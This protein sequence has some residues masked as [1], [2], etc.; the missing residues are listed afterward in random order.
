MAKKRTTKREILEWCIAISYL[1]WPCPVCGRYVI[2]LAEFKVCK[3]GR[4]ND[5]RIVDVVHP[6]CWDAYVWAE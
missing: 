3:M 1:G 4:P 6:E 5:D 2:T